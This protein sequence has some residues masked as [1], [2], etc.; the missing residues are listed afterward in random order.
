MM[1]SMMF[2]R[3]L[4]KVI[5]TSPLYPYAY[6][7]FRM[8]T[9]ATGNLTDNFRR[10]PFPDESKSSPVCEWGGVEGDVIPE[11][12][13]EKPSKK[14]SGRRG[15][16]KAIADM[17]SKESSG[18]RGKQ[19]ALKDDVHSEQTDDAAL[20]KPPRRRRRKKKTIEE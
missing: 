4:P 13:E 7:L 2:A 16:P 3:T 6:E 15:K 14:S 10:L 20:P 12:I 8:L 18:R 11:A 5:R 17:P 1:P 19:K 9:M